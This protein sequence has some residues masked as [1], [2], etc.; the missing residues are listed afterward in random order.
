MK[1]LT[2]IAVGVICLIGAQA[3]AGTITFSGRNW[4]TLDAGTYSVSN[5][6][7]GVMTG[8][9]GA[10][11]V[12]TTSLSLN[13]G[14]KVSYD[15]TLNSPNWFGDTGTGFRDANNV[16]VGDR[17]MRWSNSNWEDYINSPFD[18]TD[19]YM[20]NPKDVGATVHA[21]WVFNT[22]TTETVTLTMQGATTPFGTWSGTIQNGTVADIAIFRVGLWDS[23]GSVTLSN[24]AVTPAA[25]PE[26][27]SMVAM[28]S[29]LAGLIGFGI[30]RRK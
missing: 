5:A 30:R 24:F 9:Y 1:L 14:D 16:W 4:N 6:N 22:A 18:A 26:P 28:L 11:A 19:L 13:V 20:W 8:A 23:Q 21:E 29:G 17:Y 2:T 7:A 10:D 12:M 15:Y 27:G 25:V 3:M